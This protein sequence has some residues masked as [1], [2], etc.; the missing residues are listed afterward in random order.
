[1]EEIKLM[2]I[3]SPRVWEIK[4][5]IFSNFSPPLQIFLPTAQIVL[6]FLVF[7]FD[8]PFNIRISKPR[9]WLESMIFIHFFDITFIEICQ[10]RLGKLRM[11]L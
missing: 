2:R 3:K 10:F 7:H 5:W 11:S 4:L 9:G 6:A 1:M 8:N